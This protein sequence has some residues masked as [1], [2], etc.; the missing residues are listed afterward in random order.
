MDLKRLIIL[1]LVTMVAVIVF[2][3]AIL[4]VLFEPAIT[5]T[6]SEYYYTYDVSRNVTVNVSCEFGYSPQQCPVTVYNSTGGRINL[7][8][9]T[10]VPKTAEYKGNEK[11]YE[12]FRED[13]RSTEANDTLYIDVTITGGST[14]YLLRPPW[15]GVDIYLPEGTNY[16][17]NDS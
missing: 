15:A 1:A 9:K 17:I 14:M 5:T 2:T 16:R 13:V 3:S 7:T 11:V 12:Y 10:V 4:L 6:Y 8:V